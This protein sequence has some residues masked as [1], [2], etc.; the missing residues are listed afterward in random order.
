MTTQGQETELRAAA[1]WRKRVS[2]WP[3]TITLR[4]AI[5]LTERVFNG[6]KEDDAWSLEFV[7]K[8]M[9]LSYRNL[10]HAFWRA[11]ARKAIAAFV[12]NFLKTNPRRVSWRWA[13]TLNK[14]PRLIPD[15][16]EAIGRLYPLAPRLLIHA[17]RPR[18]QEF[19]RATDDML[20]A[21]FVYKE[22]YGALHAAL[23]RNRRKLYRLYIDF[24]LTDL[25]VIGNGTASELKLLRRLAT[26][27]NISSPPITS[28][29]EALAEEDCGVQHVAALLYVGLCAVRRAI[30]ERKAKK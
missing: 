29:K 17:L 9:D 1:D 13:E 12:R 23:M 6:Q 10:E 7:L 14:Q 20:Y 22:R 28:L 4:N 3:S 18:I 2:E 11:V 27:K 25:I 19:L 21:P 5:L 15:V 16:L 26:D 24:D 8:V 30:K